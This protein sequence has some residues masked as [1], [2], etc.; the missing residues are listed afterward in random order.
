MAIDNYSK[1]VEAKALTSSTEFQVIKFM[2]S[3]VISRYGVLH[4]MVSDNGP[5]FTGKDI[6]WFLD[7]LHTQH[8][9]A[10]MR[11]MQTNEK[12]EASN[13]VVMNGLKKR[14]DTLESNWAEEIEIILWA[15]RT[16]PQKSTGETHFCLV[17][18]SEAVDPVKLAVSTHRLRCFST[19]RNNYE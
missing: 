4:V 2:K 11:Q 8:P 14:F 5:Q 7:K 17:Y 10:S 13:K 12:V 16:T 9:F 19:E 6:K 1:W 18:I 3:R 15:I